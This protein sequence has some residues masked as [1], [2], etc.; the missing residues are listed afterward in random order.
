MSNVWSIPKLSP[1]SSAP[2]TIRPAVV[3]EAWEASGGEGPVVLRDSKA[4]SLPPLRLAGTPLLE[5]VATLDPIVGAASAV[6][7]GQ[8]KPTRTTGACC[9]VFTEPLLLASICCQKMELVASRLCVSLAAS[10]LPDV[11]AVVVHL[12][13]APVL[14]LAIGVLHPAMAPLSS[15]DTGARVLDLGAVLLLR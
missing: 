5:R 11:L 9:C 15:L 14:L 2:T 3:E 1:T 12:C 13:G 4:A 8:V 7:A 10:E 6:R